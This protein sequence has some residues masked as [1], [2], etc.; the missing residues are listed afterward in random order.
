MPGHVKERARCVGRAPIGSQTCQYEA[1]ALYG[2]R[3]GP[4]R[5]CAC[6]ACP[7]ALRPMLQADAE[8]FA[9][10]NAGV[11]RGLA[12]NYDDVEGYYNFQV[13][14]QA[15]QQ[16]FFVGKNPNDK[17]KFLH[18]TAATVYA[19][20]SKAIVA[21]RCFY[22][23]MLL[24]SSLTSLSSAVLW[25]TCA[26]APNA[27]AHGTL[28]HS[29]LPHLAQTVTMMQCRQRIFVCCRWAR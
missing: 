27:A 19:W 14:V 13:P 7:E 16:G 22:W 8:L 4:W 11:K 15:P 23:C 26:A 29:I 10:A 1:V 17:Y 2:G 5:M 24:P 28:L 9:A 6:D 25:T 20:L 12:D 18:H 21:L 3:D